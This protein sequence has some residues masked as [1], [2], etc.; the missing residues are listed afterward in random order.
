MPAMS[1]ENRTQRIAGDG[2]ALGAAAAGAIKRGLTRLLG[3]EERARVIVL[4]ACVL[5]LAGADAATVGASA[6]ALRTSL[7]IT[8]TDI[9]LLGTVTALVGAVAPL[10][11][12]VLADRARRTTTLGLVLFLWAAAMLWSATVSSFGEL[13]LARLAL[14]AVVAAA[15]PLAASLIGDWFAPSERGRIYG[16]VLAGETLGAGFCFA[17]TG[18]ISAVSWIGGWRTS[19]V[20]L[21]IPAFVLGW[22]VLRLKEPARGGRGVL[23]HATEPLPPE[24]EQSQETP[25]QLL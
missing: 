15:G 20:V 14:G 22:L 2:L 13:L 11:F 18:D 24:A 10:P 25:A 19:F 4:L 3:G 17:V 12:G 23:A 16:F 21:A 8:N 1:G 9:G 6:H 5:G 7:N